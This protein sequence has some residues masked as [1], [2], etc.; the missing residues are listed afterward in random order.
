MADGSKISRGE[1]LSLQNTQRDLDVRIEKAKKK[2]DALNE[3]A[4]NAGVP[5]E[6]RP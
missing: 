2:L 6:F 3:A 5:A 4:D 1:F